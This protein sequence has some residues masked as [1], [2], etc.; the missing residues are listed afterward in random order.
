VK[1]DWILRETVNKT[2]LDP[3]YMV[4]E[5]E[6]S[7]EVKNWLYEG[8]SHACSHVWQ[9]KFRDPLRPFRT[10]CG[11]FVTSR[12]DKVDDQLFNLVKVDT[13]CMWCVSGKA[14]E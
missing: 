8:L 11:I 10:I 3:I 6:T 12:L 9:R 1:T 4:W 13:T 7:D 14:R 2:Q 5:L